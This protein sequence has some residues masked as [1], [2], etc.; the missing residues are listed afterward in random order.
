M[1]SPG[2]KQPPRS[3]PNLVFADCRGADSAVCP[4]ERLHVRAAHVRHD[5]VRFYPRQIACCTNMTNPD[6]P[7][8]DGR[9]PS[10]RAFPEQ[11]SRR[12]D[13]SCHTR[14]PWPVLV[15]SE[16]STSAG[17]WTLFVKRAS[18]VSARLANCRLLC[19]SCGLAAGAPTSAPVTAQATARSWTLE[20]LETLVL[21]V[22]E[23]WY[24]TP[25]AGHSR[26]VH[27]RAPCSRGMHARG[28]WKAACAVSTRARQQAANRR[29]N[30]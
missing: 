13:R 8:Q 28:P 1:N 26:H 18:G 3:V 11:S 9:R 6:I 15:T 5:R 2:S 21:L 23:L 17:G 29:P 12:A 14:A 7:C 20:T 10:L 27:T 30:T 4:S 16:R 25:R 24:T 22:Q 19:T